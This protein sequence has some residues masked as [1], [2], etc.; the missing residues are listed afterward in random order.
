MENGSMRNQKPKTFYT[1]KTQISF[2]CVVYIFTFSLSVSIQD[3]IQ[4]ISEY[5]KKKKRLSHMYFDYI[6]SHRRKFS[7]K[8]RRK[9]KSSP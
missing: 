4:K 9:I 7:K 5:I 8:K 6:Y 3:A 2:C 1:R